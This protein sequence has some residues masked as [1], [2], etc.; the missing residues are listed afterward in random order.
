MSMM[1]PGRDGGSVLALVP[2]GFLVLILL[3]GLAV[4]SA[5]AYQRQHQLHNALSA[6][7]NDAVAA[8]VSDSSFYRQGTVA[9]DPAAVG[10][11]VCR[12]MEAQ[13][14]GA[15]HGLR[16]A[17]ALGNDAVRIDAVAQ[18]DAVFGRA[19]PG[20]GHRQVSSTADATLSRGAQPGPA[21]FGPAT[22]IACD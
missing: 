6:A 19:L 16:L 12:S 7:A 8:G 14:L 20:F 4:D 15:L 5:V 2:A 3:G 10:A 17:V 9:L 1:T 11:A 21:G 13:Q 22:P 18:T